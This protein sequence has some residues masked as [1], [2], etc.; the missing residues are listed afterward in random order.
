MIDEKQV[1]GVRDDDES[2]TTEGVTLRSL[3]WG[4]DAPP[5]PYY[6]LDFSGLMRTERKPSFSTD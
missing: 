5:A 4:T 2:E 1:G 6:S 3:V